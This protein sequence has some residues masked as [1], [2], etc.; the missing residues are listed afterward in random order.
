MHFVEGQLFANISD[1][2]LITSISSHYVLLIASWLTQVKRLMVMEVL[3]FDQA[4]VDE[5]CI[6]LLI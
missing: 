3:Q 6:F 5:T 4:F 1:Q 2:T